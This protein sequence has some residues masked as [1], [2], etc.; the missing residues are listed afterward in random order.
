MSLRSIGEEHEVFWR[1]VAELRSDRKPRTWTWQALPPR[2]TALV[3]SPFIF[4]MFVPLALLDLAVELYQRIVFSFLR[5]PLVDRH[6]YIRLDRQR[7]PYLDPLQKIGCAYCGYAN[8]L[9]R[10][11]SA[12]AARTEKH[13]CPI[14]HRGEEGFRPPEH[15]ADFAEYGDVAGFRLRWRAERERCE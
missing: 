3:A 11:A 6:A 12:V 2:W 4:G 13:F 1:R 14:K 7:L 10:F 9:L 5:L 15:H 8:G